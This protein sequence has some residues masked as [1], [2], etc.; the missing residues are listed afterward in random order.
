MKEQCFLKYDRIID[1]VIVTYNNYSMLYRL[2]DDISDQVYPVHRVIIVDNS[3]I[4]HIFNYKF[5]NTGIKYIRPKMNVGSAGGYWLG[6]K[7]TQ[8]RSDYVLT[9]DDDVTLDKNAIFELVRFFDT[10]KN[11]LKLF[12]ARCVSFGSRLAKPQELRYAPWR[13]TMFSTSAIEYVGLPMKELFLYAEDIEYSIRFHRLGYKCFWVPSA[14]CTELRG[15]GKRQ[16]TLFGKSRVIYDRPY[17]YYYSFRNHIIVY[18][19]HLMF[20][21]ICKLLL[22]SLK[23]FLVL[24]NDFKTKNSRACLKAIFFGILD[25]F[26][27]K[28]GFNTYYNT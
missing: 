25:G 10:N 24:I 13:G 21:D 9:L 14:L 26:S 5:K 22:Y 8:E 18:R 20:E 2:L 11:R 15:S 4:F 28:T 7:L 1:I 12:A 3:T 17:Q 27:K 23:I 16:V 19:R 6:L